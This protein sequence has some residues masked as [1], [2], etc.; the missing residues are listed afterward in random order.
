MW[1]CHPQCLSIAKCQIVRAGAAGWRRGILAVGL[2]VLIVYVGTCLVFTAVQRRLLYF[3]KRAALSDQVADARRAGLE[4][5]NGSDGALIGW[6]VPP[7]QGKSCWL[8]FHGNAG[9]ALD[10]AYYV[11]LVRGVDPEAEVLL[12]EYPGYEARPR[13]LS[14]ESFVS[15]AARA[16]STIAPDCAVYLIGES[17]GTGI[18]SRVV[19]SH[20]ARISGVLLVTPFNNMTELAGYHFPWLPVRWILADRYQ[21]DQALARYPGPVAFVVAAADEIIPAKLGQRLYQDFS[22]RKRLWLIPGAGH[23]TV[24]D[25]NGWWREAMQ[26]IRTG[27]PSVPVSGA[28]GGTR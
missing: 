1:L 9:S 21:S 17:L 14:E 10:R 8:V 18:A 28:A 27:R 26:W 5:W 19:A 2:A 15:A 11:R 24:L 16:L 12:F 3:P 25:V 23:N 4:M 6:R 7:S 22:G 13:E 20:R